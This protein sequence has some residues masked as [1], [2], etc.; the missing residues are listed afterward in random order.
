MWSGELRPEFH[1]LPLLGL[2]VDLFPGKLAGDA[3]VVMARRPD[4]GPAEV[5]E[6]L[7]APDPVAA[8][9]LEPRGFCSRDG[10]RPREAGGK[11][12]WWRRAKVK[13]ERKTTGSQPP[14]APEP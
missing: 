2:S 9:E 7:R 14:A 10:A 12:R 6:A 5:S 4:L 3:A 11:R 1:R 8:A 13:H